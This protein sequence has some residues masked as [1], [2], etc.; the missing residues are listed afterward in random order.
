DVIVAVDKASVLGSTHGTVVSLFQSVP[1]G[2]E[3]EL[4][5][6]RG[7]PSLYHV[8]PQ[9][10]SQVNARA[11]GAFPA[12]A[13]AVL[14]VAVMQSPAGPGFTVSRASSGY[15]RVTG[16]SEPRL[17]PDL[18]EG[19][20]L[21][22]VNGQR[23]RALSDHQLEEILRTHTQAGDVVLLVQRTVPPSRTAGT[24]DIPAQTRSGA[25]ERGRGDPDSGQGSSASG[26]QDTAAIPRGSERA[27]T[28]GSEPQYDVPSRHGEELPPLPSPME[29]GDEA[30]LA[31]S[32]SAPEYLAPADREPSGR[33]AESGPRP[34]GRQWG[35]GGQKGCPTSRAQNGSSVRVHSQEADRRAWS[36]SKPRDIAGLSSR[37]NPCDSLTDWLPPGSDPHGHESRG[38]HSNQEEAKVLG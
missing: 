2:A 19:D 18:R 22:K 35:T 23:V 31:S 6:R 29:T 9:L 33:Q 17:C 7:Y 38:S 24:E 1:E 13:L 28:E 4:H 25:T 30:S 27:G 10:L 3:T 14:P 36:V 15:A 8:E 34:E 26:A 32:L 20:L 11:A 21:V 12:P 5:L 16:I 37:L